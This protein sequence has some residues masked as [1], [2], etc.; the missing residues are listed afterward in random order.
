M[1]VLKDW[2]GKRSI[3][4]TKE[5]REFGLPF[6]K[7]ILMLG[8]QGCGKSLCAKAVSSQWQLRC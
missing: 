5:A 8:V 1:S 7:G 6:P 3:A 2:L 4:F